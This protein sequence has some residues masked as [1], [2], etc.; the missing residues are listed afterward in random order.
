MTAVLEAI[1]V[2]KAF[3]GVTAVDGIS[4]A[5]EPGE[6]VGLVGANGAGKTTFVNILTGYLAPDHGR[7]LY[8]GRDITARSPREV[9]RLGICRA[10]QI[11]QLYT[12]L[13]VLENA[14]L[15]V[16]A[17][18][19]QA[20]GPWRPLAVAG[21][22]AEA[23]E[24]LDAFGLGEYAERPVSDLS[25]GGLKVLDIALS[26][27]LAPRV[28]LLD[29]P[30]SGVSTAEKL[31]LMEQVLGILRARGVT[32]LFVEH[33]MEVVSRYAGR[34]L[35]FVEGRLIASGPPRQVLADPA[36]RLGVLGENA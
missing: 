2:R 14:L 17:R 10:F 20:L 36:V 27:A 13:S 29:E 9:T 31:P 35:V 26:V 15:S 18:E 5:I 33:D 4:V 22:A 30:T 12:G 6:I 21:R 8:E 28:L 24:L 16:A 23:R 7:V 32:I 11:P 19:G 1:D 34:V 25:E 3:G